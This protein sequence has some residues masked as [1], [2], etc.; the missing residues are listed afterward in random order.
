MSL[1][2]QGLERERDGRGTIGGRLEAQVVLD[3]LGFLPDR[4]VGS[5]LLWRGAGSFQGVV[6]VES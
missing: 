4:A 3:V 1:A 6:A 2:V 5:F